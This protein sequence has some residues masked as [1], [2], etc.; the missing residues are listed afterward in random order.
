MRVDV[1]QTLELRFGSGGPVR[2]ASG[3]ASFGSG[4]LIAQD[5]AVHA[6]WW[7]PDA[8][9]VEPVRVLPSREGEETFSEAEGTK[10]IKPD[11]E[12]ACQV[13]HRNQEAV[14]MLGSGSLPPRTIG[15]LVSRGP[16]GAPTSQRADLSSLYER[17]RLRL[18]LADGELN[19]EGA[20]VVGRDL[21]CFQRGHGP[22]GVP[23]GSIDLDLEALLALLVGDTEPSAVPITNVR[24]Y[25]LGEMGGLP[26]AVTD[27][28]ALAD[29]RVCV[30][31]TAE[32][33][34]DAVRD[35]PVLGSALAMLDPDGAIES[36]VRLDPPVD[37]W[38]IEGLATA[39]VDGREATLLAVADQDDPTAASRAA[40]LRVRW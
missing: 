23:S 40:W 17:I 12:A 28:V 6:A 36:V 25:E 38:K 34:P 9:R 30:S 11:L 39:A 16:D 5:D 35:G 21:R 27:A 1:I 19:V 33:A 7:R 26:L 10:H 15:V 20:C 31:A 3:V 22:T 29:G 14:I 18:G 24:H 32:D 13:R 8:D 4:W 2:A 37:G